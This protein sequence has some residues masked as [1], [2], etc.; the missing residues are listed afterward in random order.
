VRRLLLISNANAHT[1]TPYTRE[2]IA[3]ALAA[4][5]RLQLV[6]TKR[7]GHATH[8]ARG[9]AHEGV[10][11]VVVLGGDGTMNEVINGLAGSDVAMAV[12]PGGG[13]NVFA[14]SMG[15]PTD[16]VD[17]TAVLLQK[18]DQEPLRMP[19][20]RINGR[21]FAANF[22]VGLDAAIV[23]AV[24]RRQ[25]AKR[26]A[27]DAFFV[28]T[29]VR[30]FLFHTDR[31]HPMLRVSWGDEPRAGRDD[32]FLTIGQNLQ[33]YTFMGSRPMN[34]CPEVSLDGGL[35]FVG[36]D[37]LRTST[38]LRVALQTFGSGGHMKNKHLIYGHDQ[39]RIRIERPSH[40]PALLLT[41]LPIWR[42]GAGVPGAGTPRAVIFITEPDAPLPIDRLAIAEAFRLTRRESEIAALLAD[43]LDL[44]T[45]AARLGAGRGTVRD[46]LKHLFQKTGARSQVAL[47]ALLRGFVDRTQ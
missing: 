21:Y 44:E 9:A 27:G 24:E 30:V 33:P 26:I 3:N 23:H 17:A 15:M 10:D 45:I 13:A 7:Q 40:R 20:G 43:G 8:V 31:R 1:V 2:V 25:F 22:G 39:R 6:E 38:V 12:L 35:D 16:P 42:L 29:A 46:H 19:L 11:L 41:V 34:L 4:G 28:W 32:L 18:I 37:K 14:R 36:L 47:V 5:N